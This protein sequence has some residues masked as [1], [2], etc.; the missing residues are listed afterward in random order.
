MTCKTFINSS[1]ADM[2]ADNILIINC[3][4]PYCC[5]AV[6]DIEYID[7]SVVATNQLSSSDG[8]LHV[9]P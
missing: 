4:P 3:N 6:I 1:I 2:S 5:T 7:F 8:L 9:V